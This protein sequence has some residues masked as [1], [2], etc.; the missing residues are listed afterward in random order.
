MGEKTVEQAAR[1]AAEY[2]YRCI[3]L[4]MEAPAHWYGIRFEAALGDLMRSLEK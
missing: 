3:E 2:V 4:T 1:I